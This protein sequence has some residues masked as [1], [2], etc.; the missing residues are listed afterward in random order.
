MKKTWGGFIWLN[1]LCNLVWTFVCYFEPFHSVSNLKHKLIYL[2]RS[3][4][5]ECHWEIQKSLF[6]FMQGQKKT[7][8]G[9]AVQ[10]VS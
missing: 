3:G 5:G 6:K 7:P 9:K 10:A 4:N 8:V 1:Q 2:S